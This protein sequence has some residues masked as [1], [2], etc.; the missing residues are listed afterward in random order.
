MQLPS[1][2]QSVT[3]QF[4]RVSLSI[5]FDCRNADL[6]ENNHISP[7][8]GLFRNVCI[9]VT[10]S[11]NYFQKSF[12]SLLWLQCTYSYCWKSANG[13]HKRCQALTNKP[14]EGLIWRSTAWLTTK[15]KCV[16]TEKCVFTWAHQ[17]S[18]PKLSKGKSF[19]KVSHLEVLASV[20]V[21]SPN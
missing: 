3:Q 11:N 17:A 19:Y 1:S 13:A 20:I 7:K 5:A 2:S 14:S 18:L 10:N 15:T 8:S 12:E 21:L 16:L 4:S 6:S 9:D